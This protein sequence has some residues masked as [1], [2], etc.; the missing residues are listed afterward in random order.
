MGGNNSDQLVSNFRGNCNVR[1]RAS[2]HQ[3]VG[4]RSY[5]PRS[6][7][8]LHVGGG[9]FACSYMSL[10][11]NDIGPC[12]SDR[13]QEWADGISLSCANCLVHDNRIVDATGGGIV[14]SGSPG[15]QIF[16]NIVSV[17]KVRSSIQLGDLN[18][19]ASFFP[20]NIPWWHNHG[21]LRPLEY[22]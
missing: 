8:C 4:V 7:S 10:I 16:N 6:R 20:V 5:D 9:P 3:V 11:G 17:E 2:H 12:G 19:R 22:V 13:F 15:S 1:D 18:D 14:I 21:R